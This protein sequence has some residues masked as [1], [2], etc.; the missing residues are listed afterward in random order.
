M[1]DARREPGEREQAHFEMAEPLRRGCLGRRVDSLKR[2][3]G[4]IEDCRLRLAPLHHRV[5]E[6]YD[7]G[8]VCVAVEIEAKPARGAHDLGRLDEAKVTLR[9]RAES[10][11]DVGEGLEGCDEPPLRAQGSLCNARDLSEVPR[12]KGYDL[13]A[14]PVR[15]RAQDD[16]WRRMR[17]RGPDEFSPASAL[18]TE[19]TVIS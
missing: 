16:R 8:R 17:N 9:P 3:F 7:V 19:F 15:A 13:V 1:L 12:E 2:H 18:A 6:L 14:L 11:S 10:E 4:K 5:D